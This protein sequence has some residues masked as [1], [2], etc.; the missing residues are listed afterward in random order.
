MRI[1]HLHLSI[2]ELPWAQTVDLILAMRNRRRIPL[3]SPKAKKTS[4]A[5]KRGKKEPKQL[6]LFA[7]A[8]TLKQSQKDSLLE[9][10]KK[11]MNN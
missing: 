5:K 2:S 6:D 8:N 7:V 3:N 1:E 9:E 4:V 11:L 10:L